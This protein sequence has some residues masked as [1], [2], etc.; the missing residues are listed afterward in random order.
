MKKKIFCL[1]VI[2]V[3][4]ICLIGGIVPL[5]AVSAARDGAAAL[6]YAESSETE[7]YP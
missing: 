3:L 1:L 7:P 6:S 2:V 5:A 4:A